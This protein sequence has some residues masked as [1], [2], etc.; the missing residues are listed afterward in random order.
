MSPSKLASALLT[1]AVFLAP[2]AARAGDATLLIGDRFAPPPPR[3]VLA[4]PPEPVYEAPPNFLSPDPYRS[5]IRLGVGPVGAT[6]GLGLGFGLGATADFGKGTVGARVSAAWL[7]GE[8]KGGRDPSTMPL[9]NALGQYTGELVVDLYKRGPA[10]PLLGVG[11]GAVHVTRATGSGFAGVGVARLGFEYALGLSDADVRLG[12]GV[13]GVLPGPMAPEAQ[14]LTA[15]VLVTA[16]VTI[17][18]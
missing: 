9:G 18:F 1:L 7:K 10:H 8:E 11:F 6:T 3:P 14:G 5:P 16:G 13:T 4:A 17:G 15:Y 2:I 12:G